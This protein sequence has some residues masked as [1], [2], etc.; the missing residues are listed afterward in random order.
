[1]AGITD[2]YKAVCKTKCAKYFKQY[3]RITNNIQKA[4]TNVDKELEDWLEDQEFIMNDYEDAEGIP[5]WMDE[6]FGYKYF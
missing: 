4:N 1:M 6:Y 3:R 5:F 2:L